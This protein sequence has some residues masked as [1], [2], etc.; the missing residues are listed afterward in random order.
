VALRG[1]SHGAAAAAASP[2]VKTGGGTR[3]INDASGSLM[4]APARAGDHANRVATSSSVAAG[5]PV[6]ELVAVLVGGPRP[7]KGA[8]AIGARALAAT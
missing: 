5:D 8:R 1:G 7:A 2:S 4:T 6:G 3:G